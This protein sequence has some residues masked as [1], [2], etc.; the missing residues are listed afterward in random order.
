MQ[1]KTSY[2][3]STIRVEKNRASS[4]SPR[5][6]LPSLTMVGGTF[7]GRRVVIRRRPITFG[8]PVKLRGS[9]TKYPNKAGAWQQRR[10]AQETRRVIVNQG[11]SALNQ[12]AVCRSEW[13]RVGG[14]IRTPEPPSV[15]TGYE[16]CEDSRQV[17]SPIYFLPGPKKGLS[18]SR[19][20]GVRTGQPPVKVRQPGSQ[21]RREVKVRI[22][23]GFPGS[24]GVIGS[25][26]NAREA[27]KNQANLNTDNAARRGECSSNGRAGV[28]SSETLAGSSEHGHS[29]SGSSPASPIGVHS[30]FSSSLRSIKPL[31]R[32]V[33][34]M[35]P[36]ER[37]RPPSQTCGAGRSQKPRKNAVEL[38]CWRKSL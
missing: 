36:A 2:S 12:A 26:V 6:K 5:T 21:F 11:C 10:R 14:I 30:N 27:Y 35:V 23:P 9:A 34:D 33:R 13:K 37:M 32:A 20:P 15:K 29:G 16:S 7:G 4:H 31:G 25:N 38:I 28:T 19:I 22:L 18:P 8:N 3:I 24:R 1:S 17:P